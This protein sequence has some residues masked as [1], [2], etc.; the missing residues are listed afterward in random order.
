MK[1]IVRLFWEGLNIP[2]KLLFLVTL[3]YVL[4]GISSY[5][6]TCIGLASDVF[7]VIG[8]LILLLELWFVIRFSYELVEIALN[9]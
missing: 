6:I 7:N 2:F 3:L 9:P 1:F 5:A 4:F 8:I